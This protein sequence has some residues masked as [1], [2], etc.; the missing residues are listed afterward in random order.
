MAEDAALPK[1]FMGKVALVHGA[2]VATD[3]DRRL[4]IADPANARILSVTL[5]Y[6]ASEHVPIEPA[7]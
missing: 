5:D 1:G 6:A 3:T 7:P 2:Y 4:F